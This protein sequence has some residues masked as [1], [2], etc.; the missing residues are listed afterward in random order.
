MKRNEA[1][2]KLRETSTFCTISITS[3]HKPEIN[4]EIIGKWQDL[5]DICSRLMKVPSGL[6]MKLHREQIE[7]FVRSNTEG[8][9]YHAGEMEHLGLGLYC[10]TVAAKDG[11]LLI[12]DSLENE[13]WKD[14]PDVKLNMTSYL[15]MPLLWPDSEV[16]GT[17]CVLDSRKN[18]Y[19]QDY[20]DL[21]RIFRRTIESDLALLLAYKE[22]KNLAHTDQLTQLAN[23]RRIDDYILAEFNRAERYGTDFSLILID[24]DNFKTIND[25]YGY[26]VGDKILATMADLVQGNIRGIDLAGRW[27][28]EEFILIC[29]ET[30]LAGAAALAEKIRQTIEEYNFPGV[31]KATCSFGVSSYQSLDK[32]SADVFAR[33]DKLLRKAKKSGK[34]KVLSA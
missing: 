33:A 13:A 5:I 12:P 23:R 2:V 28:G 26:H 7:V 14:N 32:G 11:Y 9:P 24:A 10:E 1:R 3:Q 20:I 4:E 29:P 15:G 30:E 19:C 22:M 17:I 6:I 16:F 8:N 18:T 27:G 34:N 31:G 21:L 25:K